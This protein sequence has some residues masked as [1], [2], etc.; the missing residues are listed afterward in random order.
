MKKLQ[1]KCIKP[2]ICSTVLT[3]WGL[4]RLI[5][6]VSLILNSCQSDQNALWAVI[7]FLFIKNKRPFCPQRVSPP[8]EGN[9]AHPVRC[10]SPL[11]IEMSIWR[12]FLKFELARSGVTARCRVMAIWLASLKK[13]CQTAITICRGLSHP[14]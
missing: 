9:V 4:E 10:D 5:L 6:N 8:S 7:P 14:T 3:W 11:Q 12:T 1:D 13:V 2:L